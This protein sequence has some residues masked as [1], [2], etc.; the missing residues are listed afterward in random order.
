MT[1]EYTTKLNQGQEYQDFVTLEL[2]KQGFPLITFTSYKYQCNEGETTNGIEIKNDTLF[3][4]TGNFF[5]EIKESA[6]P[7]LYPL[8][9]G[10]IYRNDNTWLYA[11]GDELELYF[12]SK[13]QLQ[14]EHIEGKHLEKSAKT[15][16]NISSIG[17]LLPIKQAEE[18]CLILKKYVF[19]PQDQKTLF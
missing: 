10:G 1:D 16:G 3:R 14:K 5:I 2:L 11:L 12:F 13:K 8:T 17:F 9:V 6:N 18:K 4:K 15:N 7:L 19:E